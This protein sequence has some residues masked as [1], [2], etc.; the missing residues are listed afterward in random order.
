MDLDKFDKDASV[1]KM[2][3][4]D[5]PFLDIH[6]FPKW[7][8]PRVMKNRD[9]EEIE[10]VKQYI[11]DNVVTLKDIFMCLQAESAGYPG[12]AFMVFG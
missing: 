5:K 7:K 3:S 9:P 12:V 2:W 10:E 4:D 1:F 6:D 8:V 11:R